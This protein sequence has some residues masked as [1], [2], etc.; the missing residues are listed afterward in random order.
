MHREGLALVG[1]IFAGCLILILLIDPA[2][3]S[4]TSTDGSDSGPG[5]NSRQEAP[6]RAD[7]VLAIKNYV[8]ENIRALSPEKEVL[9]GTFYVTDVTINGMTGVVKYEDGHNAFI[10]DF[11]YTN[12][13]H[14]NFVVESFTVRK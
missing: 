8:R 9:G 7:Q 2:N 5:V 13:G 6:P 1:A 3:F 12:D 4:G 11:T 10:A 14:G